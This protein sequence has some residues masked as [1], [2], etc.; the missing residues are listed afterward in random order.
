M[1]S[2]C[3]VILVALLL[4]SGL[5]LLAR[6]APAPAAT[7]DYIVVL[8]NGAGG[9]GG[10]AAEHA[11]RY[12]VDVEFVYRHAL[13]GYFGRISPRRLEAIREDERVAYI[14]HDAA[15]F[16]Q[17][18]T[19]PWGIT[20]V[21]ADVSSTRAGDGRGRVRGVNVYVIDSGADTHVDLNLVGRVNFVAGS[22]GRDCHPVGHGTHVAGTIGARDDAQ[23][24]VGVAPGVRL[25][26]LKVLGPCTNTGLVSDI[27][28]AVD[29]VT[30]HASGPAVVNMSLSVGPPSLQALDDAVTRSANTGIVYTLAAGNAAMDACLISPARLG[31]ANNGII[32]TAATTRSDLEAS[33]SN[34]GPCVDIWAPGVGILST[35][36]GG[37]RPPRQPNQRTRTLD[38]TSMASPHVAGG[39][40]LYL[41]RPG[42]ANATPARVEGQLKSDATSPGTTSKDGAPISLLNVSGY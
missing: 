39:A 14:E 27:L 3:P 23:A 17:A 5:A 16:G 12:G 22:P 15:A 10:V 2:R 37:L 8:R 21:G 33:F 31:A 29:W 11:E 40:A 34:Y 32:T 18:Q 36:G 26:A 24:V 38:G 25:T 9:P 4:L 28:K 1:A 20:R 19:V 41:S 13:K 35:R 42:N 6:P 7:G 30:A